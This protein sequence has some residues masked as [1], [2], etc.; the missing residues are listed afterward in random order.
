MLPNLCFFEAIYIQT[1]LQKV[2]HG[3][4]MVSKI[5]MVAIVST[6]DGPFN[7]VSQYPQ[8]DYL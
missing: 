4:E 5:Q 2:V 1:L 8:L 7:L 3:P 6:L